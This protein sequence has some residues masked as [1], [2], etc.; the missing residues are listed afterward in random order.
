MAGTKLEVTRT[1]DFNPPKIT[2][3]LEIDNKIPIMNFH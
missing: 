3:E 1:I 2:K